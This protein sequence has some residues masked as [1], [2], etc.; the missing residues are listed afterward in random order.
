MA[1]PSLFDAPATRGASRRREPQTSREAAR[2]MSG[3]V[4]RDQQAFVLRVLASLAD[5][6][7]EWK[8]TAA[9][10]ARFA[11]VKHYR[12]LQ[13]NVAAKRLGE[14]RE[15]G[16]VREQGTRPGWTGRPCICFALTAAGREW[17][18]GEA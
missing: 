5:P 12:P 4:L 16:L 7:N 13:Q 3:H 11:L 10:V 9:E 8:A 15:K 1:Q 6:A 2:S 18:A 14:L 17:L